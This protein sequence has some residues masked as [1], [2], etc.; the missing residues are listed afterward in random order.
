V[1]I[2]AALGSEALGRPLS[3]RVL[4]E[5]AVQAEADGFPSAWTVHFST[6]VDALSVL[7]AAGARTGRIGLGVGVVPAFPR[8]PAALAQQAATV[9]ALTGGRLTLGVGV[10]HRPVIEGMHGLEFDPPV[11]RMREY[12]TVLKAVLDTGAAQ[13]DGT[14]Y[15]VNARVAVPETSPVPVLVGALSPGMVRAA[16]ELA[17][18][19]ATWLAGPRTLSGA[20]VPLLTETAAGA[21]R[22]PPRVVAAM[23]VAVTEDAAAARAAA[24]VVFARYATLEIYQRQLEREGVGSPGELAIAGDEAAVV[25]ELRRFALAGVTEMWAFPFPVGGEPEA[26]LARTRGLLASLAPEL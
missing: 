24:D 10:S 6:N 17:D 21:G 26:S 16:G 19:V 15:R 7:A 13:L 22:P 1:L 20:I 23:P 14:Y 11:A 4:V 2:A 12:L 3:P 25:A 9:Q 18:G 8:H 5:Q